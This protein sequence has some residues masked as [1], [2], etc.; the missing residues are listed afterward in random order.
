[1]ALDGEILFAILMKILSTIADDYLGP[2][3]LVGSYCSSK[4]FAAQYFL[5][6]LVFSRKRLDYP[7]RISRNL[8]RIDRNRLSDLFSP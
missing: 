7:V 2:L 3:A 8:L 6:F 1:M 5:S 4:L